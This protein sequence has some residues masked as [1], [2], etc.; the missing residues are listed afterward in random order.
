MAELMDQLAHVPLFKDLDK[1][2]LERLVRIARIR[3]YKAGE[4]IVKEGD[5]GVGFFMIANGSVDVT[6]SGQKLATLHAGEFFGEMALLD[7]Y[8]RAATVTAIG[9]TE[10]IAMSRWDFNAELRANPDIAMEMLS[11]MSRRLRE[12]EQKLTE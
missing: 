5:E 10:C 7:N 11:L 3:N 8:W 12:V 1:K 4:N 2:G 6:K 9:D